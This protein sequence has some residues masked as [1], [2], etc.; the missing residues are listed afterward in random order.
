MCNEGELLEKFGI[1]LRPVTMSE[2]TDLVLTLEK[3]N[4]ADVRQTID[5]LKQN[6]DICVPEEDVNRVAALK[7]AVKKLAY[8][9]KCDAIAIQCWSALQKVLHIM[10]CM[11]NALMTDEGIPVACETDIHGAITSVIAQAAMMGKT[12]PFFAD[13][14]IRHPENDNGELLQHCGPWPISLVKEGTRAMLGRPFAFPEHCAGAVLSEIKGGEISLLRFDGDHGKYSILLGKAKGISG[15]YN[16][17]TYL[18]VEVENWIRLEEK[19]VTG[20]YVHHCVGIHG[21]ILPVVYEACKYIPEVK[22]DF[23]DPVEESVKAWIRGE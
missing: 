11:S 7:A 1:Q 9:Y 2:F 16:I 3:S 6:V 21:D 8:E 5:F 4:D 10:P 12:A 22:L 15:P 14:S 13:W 19:L 18:W 23:Y 17:G 20:P